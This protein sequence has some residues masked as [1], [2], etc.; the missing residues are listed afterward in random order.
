MRILRTIMPI[1]AALTLTAAAAPDDATLRTA[2]A[3]ADRTP[4]SV[5]RDK[6]CHPYDTLAFWGVK[7]HQNV[8]EL[9]PTTNGYWTEI[10]A[11]YAKATGGVFTAT[12]PDLTSASPQAVKSDSAFRARFAD[13][14]KYGKVHWQT[15]SG[16]S[17]SS[18]GAPGSADL[19]ISSRYVH[20]WLMTPGE[21]DGVL[22]E[23]YTVLKPGGILAVEDHRADPHPQKPQANDAYVSTAVV[24]EAAQRAG[25]KLEDASEINANPKDTKD[26]TFGQWTLPPNLSRKAP[27]FMISWPS[28]PADDTLQPPEFYQAIGES[29]RMTLRFRKPR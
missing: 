16:K 17:G 21:F 2:V 12:A 27:S 9:I 1:A 18:L 19:V 23:I 24:V 26:Y 8:V 15:W 28:R 4:A 10:L 5:A 29:D 7:P 20:I 6:Y 11:P 22:K 25:F 14:S 13:E 3:S